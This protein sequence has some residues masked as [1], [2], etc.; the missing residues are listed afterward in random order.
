MKLEIGSNDHFEIRNEQ[1]TAAISGAFS[2][3]YLSDLHFNRHSNAI[4]EK[5]IRQINDLNPDIILLGGDYVD[6]KKHLVHLDKLLKGIAH[7]NNVFS[8][9]G[10]HDYKFGVGII[11]KMMEA[12]NV[13]W[14]E[15][16]SGT[17]TVNKTRVQI[18][19]TRPSNQNHPG[20]F[21]ILCLHHPVDISRFK[22]KYN[23]VFAGHLHGCQL[24][25][26]Q[27]KRTLSGQAI[28]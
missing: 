3:L 20:D 11:K 16:N 23:L 28:V 18:D 26:W 19:G 14:I 9:A 12:N 25:F 6:V 22:H 10:N 15:N 5:M 13:K 17:L 7:R 1:Y 27:I 21:S 2:V 4:T 24:V 8:I